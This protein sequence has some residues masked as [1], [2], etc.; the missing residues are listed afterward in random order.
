MDA[1]RIFYRFL[2]EA[3]RWLVVVFM[4]ASVVHLI[5]QS[6]GASDTQRATTRT[7]LLELAYDIG[8]LLLICAVLFLVSRRTA[9]RAMSSLALHLAE[10]AGAEPAGIRAALLTDM[11]TPL[12]G[13]IA[14]HSVG[15]F[16]SGHTHAPSSTQLRR[17]DETMTALVNTG[18]WLRQLQPVPAH[19]GAPDVFVPT[20]VQTHVRVQR[21]QNGVLVELWNRPKPAP[22][23]LPWIERAAI[24]G[25]ILRAADVPTTPQMLDRQLVTSRSEA[26]A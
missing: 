7:I 5:L 1:G 17:D 9:H 22:C 21:N 8:V 4:T 14:A 24:A 3:L 12:G 23:K 18:C 25:R 6:T 10:S 19:L 13:G 2:T 16:V 11:P 20:F 26:A 15:V